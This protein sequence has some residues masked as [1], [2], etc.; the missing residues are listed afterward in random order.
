M[1]PVW[2]TPIVSNSG[3]WIRAAAV[4]AVPAG[5]GCCSTLVGWE[6]TCYI[7]THQ[8]S[9]SHL[10][11]Q[12]LRNAASPH[13]SLQLSLQKSF[14][15]KRHIAELRENWASS[16]AAFSC[17][18]G[19]VR[20][21]EMRTPHRHRSA[22]FLEYYGGLLFLESRNG[23]NIFVGHLFEL[24]RFSPTSTA[25]YGTLMEIPELPGRTPAAG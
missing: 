6:E 16:G 19:P 9:K 12:A 4:G 18:V 23:P 14:R 20:T 17:L 22:Q 7:S 21:A 3:R 24:L 11:A 2:R 10:K 25:H 1:N 8:N 5:R 13:R 15:Y